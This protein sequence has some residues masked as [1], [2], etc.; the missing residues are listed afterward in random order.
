MMKKKLMKKILVPL[1][2]NK[3]LNILKYQQKQVKM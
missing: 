1:L 3:R 2:N